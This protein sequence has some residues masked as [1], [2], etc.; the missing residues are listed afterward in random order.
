MARPTL[1]PEERI[2]Q[3]RSP[4]PMSGCYLW[5]GV[6][7]CN[8]YGRMYFKGRQQLVHRVVWQLSRG[9]IPARMNV[10]H[11]CDNR[12]CSNIDHLFLGTT[13]QNSLD[14]MQKG[15]AVKSRRGLPYGVTVQLSGNYQVQ[16]W[17]RGKRTFGGTFPNADEAASVA[18]AIKE[19]L[20]NLEA[21]K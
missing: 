2:D 20:L 11:R 10:L 5:F 12:A 1:T 15:R 17:H 8:G 16:V 14:M 3:Y 18:K 21:A 19:N 13:F 7:N 9:E 4:E 6:T